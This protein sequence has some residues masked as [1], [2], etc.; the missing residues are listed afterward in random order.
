MGS[1]IKLAR[2]YPETQE[3]GWR[4]DSVPIRPEG[5]HISKRSV[6]DMISKGH[7]SREVYDREIR[8]FRIR[9]L[10]EVLKIAC[11]RGADVIAEVRG[12]LDEGLTGEFDDPY[13]TCCEEEF[14]SEETV[15]W[16]DGYYLLFKRRIL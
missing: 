9:A 12:E 3:V 11:E 13:W 4:L 6:W 7:V 1:D 10:E 16:L 15:N 8:D 2:F 14:Y 5:G